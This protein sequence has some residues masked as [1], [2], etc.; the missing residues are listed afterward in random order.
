MLVCVSNKRN[1]QPLCLDRHLLMILHQDHVSGKTPQTTH[2][3]CG[4]ALLS[5]TLALPAC[6]HGR[7]L[8]SSCYL[9]CS[10][11]SWPSPASH[12]K[13]N[14]PTDTS[15][16][17]MNKYLK[18]NLWHWWVPGLRRDSRKK[19]SRHSAARPSRVTLS[20]NSHPE[21][22]PQF[23]EPE[24][25]ANPRPLSSTLRPHERGGWEQNR[26]RK[27]LQAAEGV[28]NRRR[29]EGDGGVHFVLGHAGPVSFDV[30]GGSRRENPF[31]IEVGAISTNCSAQTGTL[32]SSG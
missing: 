13:P 21:H 18:E 9:R 25:T 30:S 29:G 10:P 12:K 26:G 27:G 15:S 17:R 14:T 32:G 3:P 16:S 28:G 24:V 19:S 23:L 7:G 4:P 6:P 8:S 2:I 20:W 11:S 22:H 5:R 31:C 1:K